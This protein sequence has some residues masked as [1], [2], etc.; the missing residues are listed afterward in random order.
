MS[1]KDV[2]MWKSLWE[3]KGHIEAGHADAHLEN[4]LPDLE[5]DWHHEVDLLEHSLEVAT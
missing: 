4:S 3:F 1:E 2:A 5:G